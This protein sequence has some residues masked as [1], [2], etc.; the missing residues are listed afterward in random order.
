MADDEP[1]RETMRNEGQATR[2]TPGVIPRQYATGVVRK[3]RQLSR[4]SLAPGR[5]EVNYEC[6]RI[7]RA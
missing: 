4:K 1:R 7:T 6:L 3:C 2:A 5:L